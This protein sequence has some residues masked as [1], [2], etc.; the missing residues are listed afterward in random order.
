MSILNAPYSVNVISSEMM[1]NIQARST[2]DVFQISPVVQVATPDTD[3]GQSRVNLRGFQNFSYSI[4]GLR[5]PTFNTGADS[6]EDK[7]RVEI[8]TG[9]SGFLYGGVDVGGMVNY[10]Y[11]KPTPVPYYSV[12]AGDYGYTSGYVHLDAGGPIPLKNFDYGTFGYRLNIVGQDGG[13]PAAPQQEKKFLITGVF[14]WNITPDTKLELIASHHD[15]TQT[16]GANWLNNT[17]ANGASNFDYKTVPNPAQL[18]TQPWALADLKNDRLEVKFDSKLNDVFTVR[19]AYAYEHDTLNLPYDVLNFFA[20]TL[21]LPNQYRQNIFLEGRELLVTHSEYAF[22][23]SEFQT[24]AIQHKITAG[25][26]G[27][28]TTNYLGSG[29]GFSTS[30]NTLYNI[31]QGPVYTAGPPILTPTA[32]NF[33][34]FLLRSS[35][36]MQT[37]LVI[38]DSIK[39]DDHW[40]VLLGGNYATIGEQNFQTVFPPYVLQSAINQSKLTPTYSLI[41]KPVSWATTYATYSESLQPGQNVGPGFT[42]SGQILPPFL[43][44]EYEIGAKADVGGVLLTAA[45]FNINKANQ[46]AQANPVGLPTFVQD[47]REIHQGVELTATGNIFPGLRVLGGVTVMDAKVEQAALAID[48]NKQPVNVADNFAKVTLE[49]DLPFLR[50][51]TLTGGAYYVGKSPADA[52]NV[53]WLDPYVTED[54]GLRYRTMLPAGQ[55]SIWRLSVK[56][57][58]NHAYWINNTFVG[59]PRT[60]AF[61]GTIKF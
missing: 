40:S 17:L 21:A 12:T 14:D 46:F 39:F 25:A 24:G 28:Q 45:W 55:E 7:E 16:F 11:K 36:D 50:G 5:I 18:W 26:Y 30:T 4:D 8:L 34:Q 61:S 59:A 31:S 44:K 53:V 15:Q 41:Y 32:P 2:T 60:I 37:N 13:L 1:E 27:N 54:I 56:N 10:V 51:L 29:A 43:G 58:T 6:I 3:L 23:D 33:G 9:L 48:D 20:P 19:T 57:L 47:G 42:N 49:Y 52:V 38:G 35:T 22:L